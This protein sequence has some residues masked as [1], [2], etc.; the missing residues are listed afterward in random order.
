MRSRTILSWPS[1]L[2]AAVGFLTVLPV[3]ERAAARGH[4][5]ATAFFPWVGLLLAGAALAARSVPDDPVLAGAL[6]VALL[7]VVTGGLH[8]DGWADLL[9]AVVPPVGDGAR[10]AHILRDPRVGAHAAFGVALLV[11]V[12]VVALGRSPAWA[13]LAGPILGRWAMVAS[14][15]LAPPLDGGGTGARV[16]ATA[17]PV[18]AAAGPLLVGA[19][20]AATGAPWGALV[21]SAGA[22]LVAGGL[23][24]LVAVRRL[25]G[26]NGD[27]AGAIGLLVESVLWVVASELDGAGSCV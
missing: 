10:R 15:R 26:L 5:A 11:L 9:D 1:G 23:L 19:V 27:G 22:A 21:A 14:L 24:G 25:G 2:L 17:R 13:V 18:A 6:A 20:L 4:A 16:R 12:Q 3:P 8:W 7:A